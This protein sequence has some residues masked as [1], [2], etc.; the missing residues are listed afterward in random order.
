M[1]DE[2]HYLPKSA[3]HQMSPPNS[4]ISLIR[5]RTML[6]PMASHWSNFMTHWEVSCKRQPITEYSLL[7]L[8]TN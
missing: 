7:S 4:R 3:Y 2:F 6:I 8:S 5:V 1:A